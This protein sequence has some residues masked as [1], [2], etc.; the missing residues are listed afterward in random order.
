MELYIQRLSLSIICSSNQFASSESDS[1]TEAGLDVVTT[2][3]DIQLAPTFQKYWS[4]RSGFSMFCPKRFSTAGEHWSPDFCCH[5]LSFKAFPP[6]SFGQ[7]ANPVSKS[8]CNLFRELQ[9]SADML[10]FQTAYRSIMK[11][12]E[13]GIL[14]PFLVSVLDGQTVLAGRC[15]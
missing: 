13:R 3:G 11:D 9:I 14:H 2:T 4:K 12:L 1:C 5:Y 15:S 6:C 8:R 10:N 7:L